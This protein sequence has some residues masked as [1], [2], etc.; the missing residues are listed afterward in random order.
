MNGKE[1][2]KDL[3][4]IRTEIAERNDID[5]TPAECT[6]DGPCAGVC[7]TCEKEAA[8][9]LEQLEKRAEKGLPVDVD[10][11]LEEKM[12]DLEQD[13]FLSANPDIEISSD[14]M[15]PE[16][17]LLMGEPSLDDVILQGIIPAPEDSEE[18]TDDDKN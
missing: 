18:D 9:I 12:E 11:E 17:E 7:P 1:V 16:P 5:F 2:C 3:K 14:G 6:H 15:V 8:Y 13:L 10:I 4:R